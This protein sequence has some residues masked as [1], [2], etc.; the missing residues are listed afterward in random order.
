MH[1]EDGRGV[2]ENVMKGKSNKFW[3]DDEREAI[4]E[5]SGTERRGRKFN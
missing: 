3:G 2:D 4:F 5:R 1:R